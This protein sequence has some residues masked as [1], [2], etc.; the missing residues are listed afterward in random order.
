MGRTLF[1]IH[2]LGSSAATPTSLRHTTAQLLRYYNK[3]FLLDC[4]E[5][6]QM[7]LMRYKLPMMRI[8]HIF[9]S[10][11]HG[12]HYLG[13][14]GLL[15]SLHLLGRKKAMHIYSPPG[16][17]QIIDIQFSISG[18][19]PS[20]ELIFHEITA[21]ET[22]IY[23][24]TLLQVETLEMEHRIPTYGFLFREK[25][26]ERN[27]KRESIKQYAIPLEQMAAI[28]KGKDLQTP[29]GHNVSNSKLTTPPPHP[30]SYAFCS[31]TAY[32][33]KF[34]RQIEGVD[35]LYHEATFV[36]EHA[37]TAAEKFHTTTTGAALIARKAK[38]GKLLLGHY[39]ARY[40]DMKQYVAEA[41]AVFPHTILA[42][43]GA[44]IPV[45]TGGK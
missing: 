36:E 41:C 5:G 16:L 17:K 19:E 14:P 29:D 2:V 6:T 28:K 42:E 7:Q 35:L 15:F 38:A 12:D 44:I 40:K 31:D 33:E 30:R 43:E 1:Q 10:H 21:G 34:L 13:L 45:L 9:I 8:N 3:L 26:L 25:P 20:Y 11:L 24:D 22:I 27:I 18:L 4:A 23:E 32:T 39:S 37:S